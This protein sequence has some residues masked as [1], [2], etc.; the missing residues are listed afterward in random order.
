MTAVTKPGVYD[1]S[2]EDYHADPCPVPSLSASVAKILIAQTPRHAWTAHPRL[3]PDFQREEDGAFDLGNA[4]HSL[5]LGDPKKFAIVDFDD[6]RTK[7]AK[8]AREKARADGRIPM[9]AKHWTR[10]NRMVEVGR[11]QLAGHDDAFDAFTNGKPEQTLV[12][13]E[14]GTWFRVRLD[15]LPDDRTKCFDDFKS[16]GSADPDAFQRVAYSVGHDVQAALYRR[17]IRA[18]FGIEKPRIRFI[19]QEIEEPFALSSIRLNDE[20]MD[21][22][23]YKVD[24]AVSRW[25]WCMNHGAW[26]AYPAV[27]CTIGPPAWHE[28]QVLAREEADAA[29]A[30]QAGMKPGADL[31]E[32]ALKFQAP[33]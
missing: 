12:W 15:W 16:T 22:G 26:P 6:W 2:A 27:T 3:N 25:R 5:M 33:I 31:L 29:I 32:L 14:H 18:V 23:D 10:V 4:A 9:L 1:M 28:G 17:G 30:R 8:S 24:K 13:E 11:M 19:V 21:L 20:A 7:D